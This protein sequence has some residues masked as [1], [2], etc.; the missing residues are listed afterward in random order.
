MKAA[1]LSALL[2]SQECCLEARLEAGQDVSETEISLAERI[3]H[4]GPAVQ[5]LAIMDSHAGT[6]RAVRFQTMELLPGIGGPR[7]TVRPALLQR[8]WRTI[9]RQL[10]LGARV[11]R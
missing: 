8:K 9:A 5:G 10:F 2:L 11:I 7:S 3:P 4:P 1:A 6:D